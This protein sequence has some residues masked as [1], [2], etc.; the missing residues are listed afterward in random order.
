MEAG[1]TIRYKANAV[2][3]RAACSNVGHVSLPHSTLRQTVIEILSGRE[4]DQI[5]ATIKQPRSG[6]SGPGGLCKIGL[7][8][9]PLLSPLVAYG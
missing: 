9:Q 5:M 8:L 2:A 1:G 4:I 3:G 6:A 7:R